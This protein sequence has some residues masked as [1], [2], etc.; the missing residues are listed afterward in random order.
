MNRVNVL[1]ISDTLDFGTDFICYELD[2]RGIK[3]LRINRDKFDEYEISLI[4]DELNM[5]ITIGQTHYE[6]NHHELK[7]VL[8]RAP[9]YLRDICKPGISAEE[10]LYRSQWSAFVRNLSIF[11]N[12]RWLNNPSDTFKAENKFLQLKYA[13]EMGFNIPESVVA[14][15]TNYLPSG[16]LIVK[17]VDTAYFLKGKNEAFLYSTMTNEDELNNYNLNDLPIMIQ[18]Y[19][20]PKTDIRVTVVDNEL[21]AVKIVKDS[22]GVEGDWRKAKG[23]LQYLPVDLPNEIHDMCLNISSMFNLKLSGIDLMECQGEYYF[24]EI[25]PT[26]EWAWLVS[27]AGLQIDKAICDC[28]TYYEKEAGNA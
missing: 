3:Y 2:I 17:S 7:S 25:N 9:I 13:M 21:F 18:E 22:Q 8:Y 27:E 14:N 26:G 24:V 1:I 28:L 16:Q 4:I 19:I 6:V 5:Q 15:N 20:G 23:K 10:Q 11:E 12:A